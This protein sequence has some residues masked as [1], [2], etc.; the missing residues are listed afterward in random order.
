MVVMVVSPQLLRGSGCLAAAS[1][2]TVMVSRLLLCRSPPERPQIRS[3]ERMAWDLYGRIWRYLLVLYLDVELQWSEVKALE[4]GTAGYYA[5]K[6]FSNSSGVVTSEAFP[7]S[8]R[9]HGGERWRSWTELCD[10]VFGCCG[11]GMLLS[12][13][14]S[15]RPWSW[16]PTM[17]TIWW[18]PSK[19]AV[20]VSASS[21]SMVR[22]SFELAATLHVLPAPS[23]FV[24][25]S[26]R[27]DVV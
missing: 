26:V 8:P 24:P 10:L 22:P 9:C 1:W 5:S 25:T 27:T 13:E 3:F 2:V 17:W 20:I 12:D 23:G 4:W 11:V 21:T 7:L 16:R 15:R 18:S 14:H 19:P 6:A